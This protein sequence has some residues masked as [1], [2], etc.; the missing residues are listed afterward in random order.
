MALLDGAVQW[1]TQPG[2][3]SVVAFQEADSCPL[4]VGSAEEGSECSLGRAG[5][6]Q[7]W[8]RSVKPA[9][10]AQGRSRPGVWCLCGR[11]GAR[12]LP[13]PSSSPLLS[14]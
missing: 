8:D 7:S 6:S 12:A 9:L 5:R 4:A 11:L 2:C 10:A 13:T 14:G 1:E 3:D